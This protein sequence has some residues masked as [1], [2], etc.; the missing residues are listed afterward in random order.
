[1]SA[2]GINKGASRSQQVPGLSTVAELAGHLRDVLKA[3]PR[4]HVAKVNDWWGRARDRLNSQALEIQELRAVK[5]AQE[6]TI[7]N[8]T[9]ERD[10][11]RRD[12]DEYKAQVE[13]LQ[14]AQH[15][16]SG[17]SVPPPSSAK[18]PPTSPVTQAQRW[19][20]QLD[21]ELRAQTDQEASNTVIRIKDL[22]PSWVYNRLRDMRDRAFEASDPVNGPLGTG[23]WMHRRADGGHA[24]GYHKVNW[25]NTHLPPGMREALPDGTGFY[26]QGVPGQVCSRHQDNRSDQYNGCI[27]VQPFIH[28]LAV[29]ARGLGQSLVHTTKGAGTYH[30]SHLCH[31]TSCFNPEHVWV[32]TA[33]QNQARKSCV[34]QFIMTDN[35]GNVF[36]PCP[37]RYNGQLECKLRRWVGPSVNQP[38]AYYQLDPGGSGYRAWR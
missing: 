22:D 38:K 6:T 31:N 21:L 7:Y 5:A 24:Y 18:R 35:L 8:L 32:E 13:A 28:Q 34:G 33:A 17:S 11:A 1:M 27:G 12:R 2:Q 30:V 4:E 3:L 16:E 10:E 36:H 29:V 25:R 23:C 14:H 20:M 26:E 37:H 9:Q 19:D 15:S